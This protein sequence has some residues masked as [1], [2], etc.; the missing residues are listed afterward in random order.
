MSVLCRV[1]NFTHSIYLPWSVFWDVEPWPFLSS[2]VLFYHQNSDL[3]LYLTYTTPNLFKIGAKLK[4]LIQET[5]LHLLQVHSMFH[6]KNMVFLMAAKS[7][8]F[9]PHATVQFIYSIFFACYSINYFSLHHEHCRIQ[10]IHKQK[11]RDIQGEGIG[12]VPSFLL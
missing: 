10:Y 3:C 2:K 11:C 7:L 12:D 9:K 1:R 6:Y 5:S 8:K 4:I